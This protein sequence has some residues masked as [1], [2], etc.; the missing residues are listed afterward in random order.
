MIQELD[1]P[2]NIDRDCTLYLWESGGL[3]KMRKFWQHVYNT[4]LNSELTDFENITTSLKQEGDTAQKAALKEMLELASPKLS[5]DSKLYTFN[6][7]FD[8]IIPHGGIKYNTVQRLLVTCGIEK[9]SPSV[10]IAI[11]ASPSNPGNDQ[12]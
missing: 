4:I 2:F 5:R 3:G 11:F 1:F 6:C 10:P 7:H 9:Y 12:N 8:C